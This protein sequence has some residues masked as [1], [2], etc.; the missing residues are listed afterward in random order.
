MSSIT[1]L[2]RAKL[3]R[4]FDMSD[5]YVLGFND[6][7]FGIFFGNLDIDINAS[8]YRMRG[9]SKA[10]RLREFWR[11]E[12]DLVVGN[13]ILG[14]IDEYEAHFQEQGRGELSSE[15]RGIGTRLLSGSVNTSVLRNTAEKFGLVHIKLEIARIEKTVDTDPGAAVSGAKN[16][17]ESCCKT[18]LDDLAVD[19]DEKSLNVVA[20][21]RL[22]M[23][24]LN[25][26][27][28]NMPDGAKGV[29]S[30]RRI[31]GNLGNIAQGMSELR[32]LYGTGHGRSGRPAG[33]IP[34][35]A[36]LAVTASS[37]LVQ[38]LFETHKD[39]RQRRVG[40]EGV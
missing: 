34:R 26:L 27:P 16:L 33:L 19:Y 13:S 2:E 20:L 30:M 31:L 8:K 23:E 40:C 7:T 11:I 10:K 32:N 21:V 1:P 38:F 35:H 17:I 9:K 4:L 37:A 28:Q 15:C 29:E 18:I 12:G 14:I 3:E 5:G 22:T 24:Q 25:L 39:R 36:R 6:A